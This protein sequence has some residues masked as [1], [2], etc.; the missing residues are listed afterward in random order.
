MA[1]STDTRARGPWK[2]WVCPGCNTPSELDPGHICESCE[3]AVVEE[4]VV[5]ER[6]VYRAALLDEICAALREIGQRDPRDAVEMDSD[7]CAD[8][9]EREF[10]DG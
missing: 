4:V 10:G 2:F 1:D 9:I 3:E 6:D 5:V 8:F 7:E